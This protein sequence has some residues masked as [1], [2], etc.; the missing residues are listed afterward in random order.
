MKDLYLDLLE[1]F[2]QELP[3]LVILQRLFTS[4]R[5]KIPF[6]RAFLYTVVRKIKDAR[7]LFEYNPAMDIDAEP[8]QYRLSYLIPMKTFESYHD[9]LQKREVE[10]IPRVQ[11]SPIL[12]QYCEQ[13]A[14]DPDT[15]L[16]L[17]HIS[18]NLDYE[19][20]VTLV[21]S[22]GP[23]ASFTRQHAEL[24]R[25]V[26]QLF[27]DAIGRLTDIYPIPKNPIMMTADLIIAD[28]A[29]EKL[30]ICPGMT[31]VIEKIETFAPQRGTILIEGA[32]GTGKELVADSIH[33]KSHYNRGP[34]VKVNCGA[35]PKDIV[36]GELFGYEK[37]AFTGA[38]SS[39][40]GY[41]EQ[42]QRG[43]ICLDEVGELSQELQIYLL[44]V[45]ENREIVRLGSTRRIP[46]DVRVIA[47]T[48]KDLREQVRAGRFREDLFYRLNIYPIR[49]PSLRERRSDIIPLIR[50]YYGKYVRE[51]KLK[52]PP[53]LTEAFCISLLDR[54]WPGN[55]RELRALVER[56]LT[57]CSRQGLPYLRLDPADIEKP[58]A[59]GRILALTAGQ[60]QT[61]LELCGG[62][63]QGPKGAAKYL[64]ISP[65]T[66][67]DRMRTLGM[68]TPREQKTQ[69]KRF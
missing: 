41:F 23:A 33:A 58:Q 11:D 10:L 3:P 38:V 69:Q 61:A 62:R 43:T 18:V 21:F 57:L 51:M 34:L 56:T 19:S 17:M 55:V 60:I 26:Y 9:L 20:L 49:V 54:Q 45:L 8:V 64:G 36:A 59:Q 67:R 4:L 39:H 66:L 52:A 63:I 13:F 27:I 12:A 46:L 48:N 42:A 53:A 35:I 25:S 15:S 28:T 24:L 2:S 50:Y 29:F 7:V 31:E 44:R 37:G 14:I 5:K 1:Q 65:S 32:S 22:C 6:D 16:L 30:R 68:Q 40:P 47:S